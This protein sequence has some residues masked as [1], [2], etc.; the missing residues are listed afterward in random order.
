MRKI[1]N[2]MV[3]DIITLPKRKHDEIADSEDEDIPIEE[4]GSD[5]DFAFAEQ[6]YQYSSLLDEIAGDDKQQQDSEKEQKEERS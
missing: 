5:A 2:E 4:F 3:T 1:A 6:E